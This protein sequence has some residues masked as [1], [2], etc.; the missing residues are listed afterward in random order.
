MKFNQNGFE[1]S[2][3]HA[4]VILL[5]DHCK[6]KNVK[7]KVFIAS[8]EGKSEYVIINSDGVPIFSSQVLEDT[9]V[10]IDIMA[11]A[12]KLVDITKKYKKPIL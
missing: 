7:A 11:V 8:K 9:A 4:N 12:N 5:N 2:D 10:H 1:F 6:Q 3:E